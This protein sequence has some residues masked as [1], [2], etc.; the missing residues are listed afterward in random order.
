MKP[1]PWDKIQPF[2]GS[3]PRG[4]EKLCVALADSEKPSNT[5]RFVEM[6]PTHDGGIECFCEFKDDSKWG[7]QAKYYLKEINWVK[8]YGIN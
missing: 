2:N 5:T 7:W 3:Q 4:F 1:I 6:A 8:N